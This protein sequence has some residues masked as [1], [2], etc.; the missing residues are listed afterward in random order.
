[1]SGA[2]ALRQPLDLE[3]F[4]GPLDLLLTL[5]LREEVELLELSVAELVDAAFAADAHERFGCDAASELALLMAAL[6]EL[7]SRRMLGEPDDEEPDE[8]AV[9]AAER[10]AARVIAYAPFSRCGE[11]LAARAETHAGARYRRVALAPPAATAL[12]DPARLREALERVARGRPAPSLAHLTPRRVDLPGLVRRVR[13]LLGRR[14]PVSFEAV[15]A[16]A[17]RL[18]EGMTLLAC[19]ELARRGEAELAQERPFADITVSASAER[20]PR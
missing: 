3:L 13:G 2:S 6:A 1:V 18:E 16:G 4:E 19:L 15:V 12:E 14:R 8:D 7:K 11:W 9:E 20:P 5:V 17:D 10:L